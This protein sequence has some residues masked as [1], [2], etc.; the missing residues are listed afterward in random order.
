MR[1]RYASLLDAPWALYHK[2]KQYVTLASRPRSDNAEKAKMNDGMH[3]AP[4]GWDAAHAL[5][6][7]GPVCKRYAKRADRKG[8]R[9][10]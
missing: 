10:M 2:C 6:V 1:S 5:F 8:L 7:E 9:V 4:S 3:A